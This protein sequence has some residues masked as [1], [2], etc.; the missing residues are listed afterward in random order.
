[1]GTITTGI[2]LISGIDTASL[3]SQLIALEARGKIP[4]QTKIAF[5]KAKQFALMD[6]N[7]RLLSLKTASKSFR[8]DSIFKAALASSSND[9]ILTASAGKLAQPGTFTFIVKQLVTASQKLSQGYADRNTTPLSLTSLSFEFGKGV[10]GPDTELADL[11][12]GAGIDRGKIK[13]TDGSTTTTVDLTAVTTMNEVLDAINESGANVTATVSGDHIVVTENDDAA[14]TIASETGDTTAED[15]GIDGTA[16]GGTITGDDIRTLGEST[17]LRSL[18]DGNGVIVRNNV[19]DLVIIARDGTRFDIDLGR[20]DKP[21]DDETELSDL[22][23]GDGIT[24]VNGEPDFQ[25][26]T[27]ENDIVDIDLGQLLDEN[28]D[29]T[30]EAVTTVLELINRVNSQL[31]AEV[32]T[33]QVVLSINAD[34]TGFNLT[35]TLG[36]S[37]TLRVIGAGPKGDDTAQDLGILATDG[38]EGDVDEVEDGIITGAIIPNTVQDPAVVTI[39]DVIDRIANAT[40]A[41]GTPNDGHIEATLAADGVSL[42][43][44]DTVGGGTNL[45]ITGGPGGG[46]SAAADLGIEAD[47]ASNTVDGIRLI[48]GLNSV[49]VRNLNGGAGL[50]G[51][52]SLTIQDGSGI[53][54][55]FTLD[56]TGSLSDI[57]DQINAGAADVTASLNAKGT[58]LV[59]T[60][61]TSSGMDDFIISGVAAAELNITGTV[62]DALVGDQ[63]VGDNLQVRYVSEAV[64]LRDMNYGRGVGLGSFRITDGYGNA[65]DVSVGSDAIT[66]FDVIAEINSRGIAVTARINDNG[67]GLLIEHDP[68]NASPPPEGEPF[69]A[70][71]VE[72]LGGSAATDLNILGEA[73]SVGDDMLIDGSYERVVTLETGD[74]LDEIVT[75]INAANIPVTASV[76][77]TGS[78]AT[79]FHLTL[80][81]TIN[82]R[83]GE[84]IIDNAPLTEDLGFTTLTQGQDAKV[85]FGSTDPADGFLI[86]NDSNTIDDLLQGV[87]I[88]LVKASDEAVTV[89]VKRDIETIADAV[90]NFATTFNDAIGRMNDHDFFN[91]DTEERGVLLGD[92]T[93]SQ[94]RDGLHRLALGKPKGVETQY[95]FLSQVG[96]T[97]GKNGVL[98]FDRTKFL[99]AYETDPNAVENLFA[100]FEATTVTEETIG[101]GVTIN[102][103]KQVYT[104][105]GFG[106]LFDQLLERL[107]NSIDGTVTL[108]DKVFEDQIELTEKRIERF[109]ERLDAKRLRLE[110]QFM[111]M[112]RALALLQG[113]SNALLSLNGNL[114]LAQSFGT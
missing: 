58:G 104:K 9:D 33:D 64:L 16:G 7:T 19:A 73:D 61:N 17:Q 31:N 88:N 68:A 26:I 49:L 114:I 56:E 84:L 83:G 24:I 53:S 29:V 55:T 12:G 62:T 113:Q 37:G 111:A 102:P 43:I 32:A 42:Q 103:N 25:I 2:G 3:I 36:G 94:V 78:G 90:L 30:D 28:D 11:N 100:A 85:F 10:V 79:P 89:T 44:D 60:N 75:K 65:E 107:T 14:L 67:D 109:D 22:N 101:E 70:I 71:K 15:L 27:T 76:I 80:T 69:V 82:G 48:A 57:I 46:P 66:L 106:E 41:D 93:V 51:N 77:N 6:I 86:T 13:I 87:T 38:G 4:L 99:E 47:V 92:N 59:V 50:S 81:S 74:T 39:Q 54:D 52:T 72:S 95:Q 97:L 34:G 91:V 21:I 112:E 23:N 5:L 8:A 105:L 63:I 110:R 1:M 18:N 96:L 98:D 35:D 40:E 108:A 45:I 20:I